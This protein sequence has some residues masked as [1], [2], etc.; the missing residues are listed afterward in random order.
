MAIDLSLVAG[1]DERAPR[2]PPIGVG[3]DRLDTGICYGTVSG[4]V[5]YPISRNG[6]EK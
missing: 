6:L 3:I 1:N 2:K 5:R 4:T